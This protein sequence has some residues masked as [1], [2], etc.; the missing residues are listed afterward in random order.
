MCSLEKNSYLDRITRYDT[1]NT[2]KLQNDHSM[3][4][5]YE[6]K[7]LERPKSESYRSMPD[8]ISEKDERS[9]SQRYDTTQI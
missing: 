6:N 7:P 3:D 8:G 5:S 9:T 2:D 4:R 1:K